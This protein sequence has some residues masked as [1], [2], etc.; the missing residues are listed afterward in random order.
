LSYG[1][2][3]AAKICFPARHFKAE[4]GSLEQFRHHRLSWAG[5]YGLLKNGPP[6]RMMQCDRSIHRALANMAFMAG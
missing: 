3:P 5:G 2:Q 6:G 4:F 1:H